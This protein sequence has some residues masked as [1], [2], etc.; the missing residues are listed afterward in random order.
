METLAEFEKRTGMQPRQS[1]VTLLEATNLDT[2]FPPQNVC[3]LDEWL[4]NLMAAVPAASRGSLAVSFTPC[5]E[6]SQEQVLCTATYQVPESARDYENRL[7][8]YWQHAV[9]TAARIEAAER[10]RLAELKAKY[11]T[12]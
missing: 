4:M 8:V 1:T 9:T 7:L 10:C 2:R 6:H 3:K 11:E 5:Y 12:N